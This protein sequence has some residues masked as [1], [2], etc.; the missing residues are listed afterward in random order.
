MKSTVFRNSSYLIFS[1][2]IDFWTEDLLGIK[3]SASKI[4]ELLFND[5]SSKQSDL[6]LTHSFTDTSTPVKTFKGRIRIARRAFVV[7]DDDFG[8]DVNNSLSKGVA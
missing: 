3:R 4:L 8:A 2:S 1:D 7:C 5:D 6:L